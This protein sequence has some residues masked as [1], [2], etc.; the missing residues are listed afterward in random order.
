MK[1][2]T[3]R[4]ERNIRPN[5]LSHRT[6]AKSVKVTIADSLIA[7][8]FKQGFEEGALRTQRRVLLRLLAIRFGDLPADIRSIV[9]HCQD[10]AQLD[11]WLDEVVTA[12]SLLAIGIQ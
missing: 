8:G 9:E 5:G 4:L 11:E 2:R 7:N 12:K 1:T 10:P 6:E 3:D